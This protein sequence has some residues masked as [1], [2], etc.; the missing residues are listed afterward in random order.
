[1]PSSDKVVPKNWDFPYKT[2]LYF[3]KR[4]A[5]SLK[6][7]HVIVGLTY[8]NKSGKAYKRIQYHG[9]V[10]SVD[11][12][13]GVEIWENGT[14]KVQSLPPDLRAWSRAKD[15]TYTART[16]GEEVDNVDFISSW[17][18]LSGQSQPSPLIANK[19]L[20]H[21]SDY[22]NFYGFGTRLV[23]RANK[24]DDG[25]YTTT[26][27][28]TLLY[29]P[30]WPIATYRISGRQTAVTFGLGLNGS[31]GSES[32][33]MDVQQVLLTYMIWLPLLALFLVAVT[34]H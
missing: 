23:G 27:W 31:Y 20:N 17:V 33:F 4:V 26:K 1:M 29:F 14:A 9:S 25:T 2:S 13:D 28:L 5:R 21:K 32:L 19:K 8:L 3:N 11:P 12:K 22:Y 6:D 24:Q 15:G 30:V 34:H 16:S 18:V 10:L 7:K